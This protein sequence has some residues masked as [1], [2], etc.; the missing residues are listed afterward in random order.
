MP[1]PKAKAA[2]NAEGGAKKKATSSSGSST[3]VS[4]VVEKDSS[5]HLVAFAGGKPDKKAHDAEQAK[6]K[7]EIDALQARL[8]SPMVF[9]AFRIQQ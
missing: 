3:P 5:D 8:V 1:A 2:S 4:S 6:I 7:S 9:F